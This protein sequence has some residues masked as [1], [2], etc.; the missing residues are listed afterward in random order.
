MFAVLAI[1]SMVGSLLGAPTAVAAGDAPSEKITIN[2]QT[3]NGSGC[4]AGSA[5]VIPAADNTAFTVAY[6]DYVAT[7][8]PGV[9]P[10]DFRKNC[11][12][13]L[14]VDVPHGFT[15]AIARADYHG[16]AW[17]ASGVTARQT[18]SYYFMG[19][20]P[21][22]EVRET[23]AGPFDGAWSTTDSAQVAALVWAPCGAT[24]NLNVNTDLR[25]DASGADDARTGGG[26]ISMDTSRAGV[27]T[28]YHLDWRRC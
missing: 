10:T 19:K 20:A 2:V 26:H 14:R 1:G 7:A 28:I 27:R 5:T 11:Q 21:T 15:Y 25:V 24:V 13:S 3:V 12:L 4:P 17:L 9:K 18:A 22:A 6:S 16:H 23:F 8:G